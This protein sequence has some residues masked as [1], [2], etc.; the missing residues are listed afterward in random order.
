[1][2][3][4]I[5]SLFIFSFVFNLKAGD[6][7]TGR[8]FA[9]RSEVIAT[10]GMVATSQP[11][12]AQIGI[13]ILKKGGNAIDAAIAVN[14]ALGLMEPTSCGIGGDLFA[15]IWINK[16]K[17]LY[18]LNASGPAPMA[19][20]L[21]YF[22]RKGIKRIPLHGPLPW[23]V[24]G[25]VDGWFE[26]H[27]R[28]GKLPMKKILEPAIN[29]A[30]KGFPLSEV[31][32]YYWQRAVKTFKKYKNFQKLYAPGGKIL[33]KGDIFKNPELAGTYRLIAEKGRDA[34]YKGEIAKRIIE[35]SK[36]V[37]GFFQYEDFA[38]FHS[39][40]VQPLSVNYRG[41][42]VWELPPNG[43]GIAVLQ[44]L[45]MLK[46]F[47]LKSM[48]HNSAEY[49]HTLIEIK[50]IVYEDRARFYADPKF[51]TIPIKTLLSEEYALKRLEFFNPER[52][53]LS[54]PA[55]EEILEEGDTAYLTVVDKDFNAVSLIQSNY[56][57][58]G[59]GMVPDGLG[60]C[61][62]DRGALFS[63]EEGHPNVIAP[64]KRPFHTI[65]PG[66]V[67]KDNE[68][69]FSFGVMGGAMQPQG[70]VQILCNIIDFGMNIQEAG[71]APRFRHVGSSQPNGGKM[72]DGGI[73]YLESGISSEVIRELVR[74]G[75]RVAHAI[76]VFGGYQGIWIDTKRGIL[77][78]ASESRKDGCA[79]GY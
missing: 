1:M 45:N 50:K 38:N 14:A 18:G 44:M 46:K 30:E 57:G 15:I 76:G 37:G 29:Y 40:W 41:Y 52:A 33:K 36:K 26:L 64:G 60:F 69:V 23:T 74:K 59:S 5:L 7:I 25:C 12:A 24:P 77:I 2:K 70:H 67:T 68:P 53:N 9:T 62:Q 32:A 22:K 35:Y 20:S 61:L 11:L 39:E 27:R 47:D 13:D 49:L 65:I 42:D 17:K 31:I 78:G 79:I 21:E 4:I 75:H 72:E 28:F 51:S 48:G 58:F 6:R 55:G 34:F 73:V 56:A 8:M 63:L 54:I 3:K 16:E 43:Q 19:I 66:F 10:N 71:D